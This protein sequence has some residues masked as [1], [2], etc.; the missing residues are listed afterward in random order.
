VSWSAGV[1]QATPVSPERAREVLD[2]V[3]SR[4][5]FAEHDDALAGALSDFLEWLGGLF[6][7]V[8][9]DV[10]PALVE[11][12]LRLLL[13]SVSVIAGV[14]LVVYVTSLVRSRRPGEE[15]PDTAVVDA[16]TERVAS[17]RARAQK[18]QAAGDLTRALRLY[19]FAL[20]VGLG[21]RGELAYDDAWTNQELLERGEP[22]P[23]IDRLL[24]PLVCALDAH[25]FGGRPTDPTEVRRFASLCERLLDG[26]AA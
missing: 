10:D 19:F 22:S 17:L 4:A 18:A 1:A 15:R 14:M 9:S 8:G 13:L 20:V 23:E 5:E 6:G 11:G 16:L 12:G 24:G 21:E 7:D 2:D 3:L 26:G 25:S